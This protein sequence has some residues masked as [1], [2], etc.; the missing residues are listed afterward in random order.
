MNYLLAGSVSMSS[1]LIKGLYGQNIA[2]MHL[3][4]FTTELSSMWG[5]GGDPVFTQVELM[6]KTS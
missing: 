5:I 6:L 4:I 3:E 2:E 1:V